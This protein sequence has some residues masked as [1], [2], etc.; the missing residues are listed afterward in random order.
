MTTNIQLENAASRLKL[1]NFRGVFMI[2]EI[3]KLTQLGQECGILA[4][5]TSKEDDMHWTCWFKNGKS[6]YYFDS[7]GLTP[8]KEIIKYLKSPILYSTFQIQQFNEETCGEWC[9]YVLDRL[10]KQEDF[11]DII[12]D[13]INSSTY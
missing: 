5:K 2:D 1:K 12:L 4:S 9:L 11:T 6:K 13:V 10:N 7:F 8:T 3:D